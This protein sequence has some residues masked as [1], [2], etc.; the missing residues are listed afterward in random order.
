MKPNYY[1][2]FGAGEV[3]GVERFQPE[4][5]HPCLGT[6]LVVVPPKIAQIGSVELPEA[7]QRTRG[8]V[9]VAAIPHDLKCPVQPGDIA[10]CHAAAPTPVPFAGR[11][12]LALLN[13][14][15]DAGTEVLGWF[16]AERNV[17]TSSGLTSE[18]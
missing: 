16:P 6:I 14:C 9:R 4:D 2:P 15:D 1:E 10:V 12:D 18:T 8:Y 5:F 3:A 13:Y 7:A 17:P 11:E